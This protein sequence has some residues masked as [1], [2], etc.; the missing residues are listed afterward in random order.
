MQIVAE[1]RLETAPSVVWAALSDLDT[2]KRSLPGCQELSYRSK[3]ALDA[4]VRVRIGA[5]ATR[6][7]GGVTILDRDPPRGCRLTFESESGAADA[8]SGTVCMRL[9]PT[10]DGTLVRCEINATIGGRLAAEDGGAIE[11][12]AQ[13]LAEGFLRRLAAQ[14]TMPDPLLAQP[15]RTSVEA[16]R[17]G[18][19]PGIW[20]PTLI[21]LVFIMLA[22]FAHLGPA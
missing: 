6:L 13:A 18:L 21:A 11:R 9:L 1:R 4:V 3:T 22:F 16:V 5:A 15:P 10:G 14:T 19:K 20:V 8:G 17:P 2:V 12:A 7:V